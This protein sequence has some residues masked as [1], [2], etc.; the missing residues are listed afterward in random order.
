MAILNYQE[1]MKALGYIKPTQKHQLIY[2]EWEKEPI[3]WYFP[4]EDLDFIIHV[5][6][7]DEEEIEAVTQ[8]Y[9]V[10]LDDA[11]LYEMMSFIQAITIVKAHPSDWL[12][13]QAPK[14]THPILSTSVIQLM[15]ILSLIPLAKKD[16]KERSIRDEHMM[17]NLNH[18]KGYIKNYRT[19]HQ[20]VGIELYGWTTYLASLGLIHLGYLH[21]MH[22]QYND[23]FIFYRHKLTSSVIAIAKEGLSVRNDGQFDGVNKVY[24]L[25]NITTLNI[26][27]N[28]IKAYPVHPKGFI[29]VDLMSIRLEDYECILKPGDVV[30]DFHIPTRSDYTIYGIKHSFEEAISFFQN[31]YKDFDYQAFWCTSWLYSPQIESLIAKDDSNILQVARQGYRLPATPG[32]ESLYTFVFQTE[33]PDFKTIQPKTSLQS[34]VI[35]YIRSGY[36]INAGCYL[37]FIDDIDRFGQMPYQKDIKS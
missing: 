35:D 18:L 4:K 17:F 26:E 15:A 10:I 19:K 3:I 8:A 13:N 11:S 32:A 28:E 20:Q 36:T 34:S 23:P 14:I 24:D 9:H 37:Y 1:M 6:S 29:Q 25:R 5:L 33:H 22:H 27:N 31:H 21:F 7:L 16:Y 12:A 30:I 2:N